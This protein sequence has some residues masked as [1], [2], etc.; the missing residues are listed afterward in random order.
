LQ[1]YHHKGNRLAKLT[2]QAFLKVE[3]KHSEDVNKVATELILIIG[4]EEKGQ[5]WKK[6]SSFI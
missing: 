4:D 1:K 3:N 5:E 2:D 6:T